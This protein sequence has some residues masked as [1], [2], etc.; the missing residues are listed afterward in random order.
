M[1]TGPE[2]SRP[3][4]NFTLPRLKWGNQRFLRCMK[5]N[6]INGHDRR[7]STSEADSDGSNR[8]SSDSFKRSSPLKPIG[9]EG[10]EAVREKL[11]SDLRDA[12]D[13]MK[14]T[15]LEEEKN[16]STAAPPWNLR[17][18]RAAC[19][20][21]NESSAGNHRKNCNSSP[22]R[23]ESPMAETKS[24]RL[25]GLVAAAEQNVEKREKGPRAKFSVS[26]SREEV[27][28]DFLAA[29]G[30]RPPRRPKKRPR[31]VQ[32]QLDAIFPGLW[33]TEITPDTYKVPDIPESVKI[34]N[35]DI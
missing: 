2:R 29:A 26:L 7:L 32:K 24:N 31:I 3:L 11:M 16:D 4:H 20:A 21:P 12:A 17:T 22:S 10:I 1:A 6:E 23:P 27:E 18:R 9:G 33:L 30:I 8:R 5:V 14:F 25:R 28:R 19:K 35:L 13:K 15:I 34:S